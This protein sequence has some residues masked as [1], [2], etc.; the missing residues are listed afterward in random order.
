MVQ[1][2]RQVAN[3]SKLYSTLEDSWNKG[4]GRGG[5]L[6]CACF[7]IC[8][9]ENIS[10]F[11][12]A[13]Y[14]LVHLSAYLV[15]QMK[16][17]SISCRACEIGR[18]LCRPSDIDTYFLS[19]NW[20]RRDFFVGQLKYHPK[21]WCLTSETLTKWRRASE[22]PTDSGEWNTSFSGKWKLS[23]HTHASYTSW[24]GITNTDTLKSIRTLK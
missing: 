15:A 3:R 21:M 13:K 5:A 7:L 4:G 10:H 2:G 18:F 11:G 1:S 20:N 22:I 17:L 8:A 14:I 12:R 23:V 9:G 6:V 16:Y 19:L 24:E